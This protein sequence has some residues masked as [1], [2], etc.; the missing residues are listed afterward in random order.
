[1]VSRMMSRTSF[2]NTNGHLKVHVN[3]RW[4][5]HLRQG[6]DKVGWKLGHF[7]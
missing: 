2:V 3:K 6:F 1:M 7:L 5:K 4:N